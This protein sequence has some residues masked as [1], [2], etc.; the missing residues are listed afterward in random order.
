MGHLG[1][2]GKRLDQ[3]NMLH[4]AHKPT[5]RRSARR[6]QPLHSLRHRVQPAHPLR[7]RIASRITDRPFAYMQI[8]SLFPESRQSGQRPRTISSHPPACC[9]RG[10]PVRL[11]FPP[12]FSLSPLTWRSRDA[13]DLAVQDGEKNFS[14]RIPCRTHGQRPQM[15]RPARPTR[16]RQEAGPSLHMWTVLH[17]EI[18]AESERNHTL[19]NC[20]CHGPPSGRE[21]LCG[22][23]ERR[24][25]N[26]RATCVHDVRTMDGIA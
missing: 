9:A 11:L 12:Y 19:P 18:A 3:I 16:V 15:P 5:R 4:H 2:A 8:S 24:M 13:H 26:E 7:C 20:S 17:G 1:R 10:Q 21:G 25:M 6:P 22:H 14:S 23:G